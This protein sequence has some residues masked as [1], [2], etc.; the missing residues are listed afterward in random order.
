[1]KKILGTSLL[2][3]A[4]FVNSHSAPKFPFPQQAKYKYGIMPTGVSPKHVQTVYEVWLQGY[5]DEQP[6]GDQARIKFDEDQNTV[7]EGIGYGM[8][9]M[10]YMDN[11]QNNTKPKF[12]KL[13]KYYQNHRDGN[14]L[15]NWK[16]EG[17]SSNTP[18]T[19]AATDADL[20]AAIALVMADKQWPGSGY[21]G[22]ATDLI[23]RIKS[24]EVKNNILVGGDAWDA[25][26]PSYMS[27]AATQ[28][29]T[30]MGDNSWSAVQSNCYTLLKNAQNK[31][32]ASLWPNWCDASGNAGGGTGANPTLYGFD[33]CRTPWRLGWAYVWY[34]HN[35]ALSLCSK[36]VNSFKSITNND[37]SKI[38][39]M[40]NLDG[41]INFDAEGSE[42]NIPTYLGPMAVAGM[43][44]SG[45]REWID[46][47]YTRL[48]AF[49]GSDD[50]YYNE[51][52]ELL[53]MLL[54]TGNMPDLTTAT[55]K[56]SATLTVSAN[57]PS[58]GSVSVS[59][60]KSSYSIGESVTITA[61]SADENRYT[62]TG[63]SGDFDGTN[64]ST[65]VKVAYD[66]TIL[67]NFL[68]AS[69]GDLVDDCED[70]DGIT[71]MGSEWFTYTDVKDEGKS[72]VTP[73]TAKGTKQLTMT[74]GG[75]NGSKYAVKVTY[76]LDKGN[77]E[78][79][80]FVGFGFEM[81]PDS[82]PLDISSSTG[83]SFA[84]KGTFG[85]G[86][87]CAIKCESEAV[88][89]LGASYSY[90]LPASTSWKEISLSWKDDFVQPKWAEAVDLDLKRVPKIQWQIQGESGESGEIWLDDIHLIGMTISKKVGTRP[91]AFVQNDMLQPFCV[92]QSGNSATVNFRLARSGS[93]LLSL[94]DLTGRLVRTLT[95]GY[96]EAGGHTVRIDTRDMPL[97]SSGYIFSLKSAEG[98]FAR[99]FVV[100]R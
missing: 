16:I 88:T 72:T 61:K 47:A 78:Y 19:G 68:D 43:V 94:H 46:K 100:N 2:L 62:F 49:G 57:P 52:L 95:E 92:V 80:P 45:Y 4:C 33:A 51:C 12:D 35:D 70:N 21:G 18:G 85:Q 27:T 55:P 20:D 79:D 96:R 76:T 13:W 29:F 59:P 15:M 7:S 56:S 54:L 99:Q 89:E 71:N 38:G 10:V 23:G 75:Y 17:F 28:L 73:V 63:W 9:I 91:Q 77:F 67:A 25:L 34:N 90:T 36:V 83:I 40:Y 64:A 98:A 81:K 3:L 42:D 97:S 48:R 11:D 87:T 58:A 32:S 82:T 69:G 14:G 53:S 24:H 60:Q 86:D 22:A 6:G 39:Q 44:S 31:S 74:S 30:N 41:S 66:M 8:I 84:Y 5:Y 65:T 1:M 50:N 26:N 93:V 37:P